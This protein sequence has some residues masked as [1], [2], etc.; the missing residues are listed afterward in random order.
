MFEIRGKY[1]GQPW[2]TI[3]TADDEREARRLRREYEMAFG[4]EWRITYRRA[5]K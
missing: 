4:P 2:E 3:D 5:P 1:P